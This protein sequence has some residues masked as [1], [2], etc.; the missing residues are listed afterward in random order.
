M[1][2]AR[3]FTLDRTQVTITSR[4]LDLSR[5]AGSV[6]VAALRSGPQEITGGVRGLG[7]SIARAMHVRFDEQYSYQGGTLLTGEGPLPPNGRI[8]LFVW[9]GN[10]SSVATALYNGASTADGI[11]LLDQF[12]LAEAI[13]GEATVRPRVP[14]VAFEEP[15]VLAKEIPG[16][17]LLEVVP[18]T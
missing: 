12:A 14:D 8:R 1:A 18:L 15:P 9:E 2:E 17:G 16:I 6:A 11:A 10:R 7:E 5:P 3:H 13:T 4:D